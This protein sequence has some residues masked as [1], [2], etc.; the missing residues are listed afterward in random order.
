MSCRMTI[1]MWSFTD[2]TKVEEQLNR[3]TTFLEQHSHGLRRIDIVVVC[4]SRTTI[5]YR[6]QDCCVFASLLQLWLI[7][8]QFISLTMACI[9]FCKTCSRIFYD[10]TSSVVNYGV[11]VE[12]WIATAIHIKFIGCG[13]QRIYAL[14]M[15]V[16]ERIALRSSKFK[17]VP[18]V[19]A[20]LLQSMQC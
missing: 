13:K 1:W 16:I 17:H 6:I 20:F 8:N 10:I 15:S 9:V 19:K 12:D 11:Y 3:W 4:T 7:C 5:R 2:W 18:N 14:H